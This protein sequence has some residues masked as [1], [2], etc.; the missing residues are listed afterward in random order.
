M[1]HHSYI[2][3]D[4]GAGSGRVI[5]GHLHDGKLTLDEVHRFVSPPVRIQ[6]T[7]RWNMLQIFDELKTGLRKAGASGGKPVSVSVD[8]W[9]LDYVL[10]HG[11]EPM[12]NLPYHYRDARTD[13]V[14][15]AA[16]KKAGAELIFGE[17]GIEFMPINTLYQ[18]IAEMER[19]P[20]AVE[21]ADL[22][23][24]IAD[25]FNY[26]FSGVPRAEESLVSTTQLYNPR[27]RQWSRKLIAAFGFPGRIFPGIV[28]PGTR[29]GVLAQDIRDETGLGGIDVIATCSHDTGAAVAAVP[30]SGDDWAFL[31]SG[32]WSLI[33]VELPAPLIND[34][35]RARNF[36]NEAGY[37]GTTCLL[38]NL[39][40]MWLLQECRRTW[41]QQGI[42]FDYDDLTRLA[43][44]AE[45]FRSL[46]N[47]NDARFAKPVDMPEKIAAFCRESGQPAPETQGQFVRCVLESL[48]L[49]YREMLAELEHLTGRTI[50]KLH[51]VGGGSKNRLLNQ[52]AADATG[53]TVLAGPV[54]AT[55]TGN[56]L[57]QAITLGHVKS[58]EDARLIVRDSFSIG[59]FQPEQTAAWHPV[60]TRFASIISSRKTAPETEK[61]ETEI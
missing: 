54:E 42:N 17:T 10:F 25:Y 61:P 27:T 1:N 46:I 20:E 60:A 53:C 11:R 44:E 34:D 38:K 33:G 40:G 5:V 9:G 30:A 23:L 12:L 14:F 39:A 7:L 3:C 37:G 57:I 51:I 56:V 18:L 41:R 50:R 55:A 19:N 13:P 15:D 45:P 8:S 29:L 22:F 49:L 2:A 31:S 28:P 48:A 59:E 6:D 47:P 21:M 52:L 16:L 58:L 32:T 26:L 4:L 35:V 43:G 36:S 24:N